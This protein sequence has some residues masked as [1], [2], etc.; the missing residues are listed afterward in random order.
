MGFPPAFAAMVRHEAP[1][2]GCEPIQGDAL[3][4]VFV[5]LMRGLA[6]ERPLI[7]IVEDLHFATPDSRQIVLSLAR[8]VEGRPILLLLT[9]RPGVPEDEL[10]HFSRLESF[11]RTGIGRLGAREVVLLLQDAFKSEALADKLELLLND[12]PLRLRLGQQA[13]EVAGEYSWGVV[14]DAI[15]AVYHDLG[16][17]VPA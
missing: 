10:A 16:V 15:E 11:R 4:T 13:I 8:A 6:A 2:E 14:A 3:H 5:H 9:T 7:W 12:E 1:P 17:A